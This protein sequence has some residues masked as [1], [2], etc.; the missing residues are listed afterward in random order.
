MATLKQTMDSVA[1]QS[2][3]PHEYIIVDGGSTD[4]TVEFAKAHGAATHIISEPDK[5]IADAFNKGISLAKGEWIGIIN[6][7]DWYAESTFDEVEKHAGQADIVH[8]HIQYWQNNKPKA[9][10][11]PHEDTLHLE[12][13]LNHPSVFAR[14]EVYVK[15]GLFDPNYKYAMDYELLLR[16][17]KCSC[18][19]VNTHTVMAHMRLGGA[20]DVHW[21]AAY[22]ESARAKIH[23]FG[24]PIP[25]MG[26]FLWQVLRGFGRR[27]FEKIGLHVLVRK[28]RKSFSVM[29]KS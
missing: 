11:I 21:C 24:H 5:G 10:F 1:M 2:F 19:F 26:Y 8:G 17:F 4:G 25:N 20:S 29:R 28:Y 7:D 9:E 14:K 6:S 18:R 13:T 3:P 23:H 16:F 22:Y 12:M 15:Y 27:I